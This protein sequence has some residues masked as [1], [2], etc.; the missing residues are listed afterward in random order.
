M[1]AAVAKRKK[2]EK[3]ERNKANEPINNRNIITI[4]INEEIING[5]IAGDKLDLVRAL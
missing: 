1:V 5:E 4:I 2:I 3:L